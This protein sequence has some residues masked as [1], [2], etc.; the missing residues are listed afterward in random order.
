[1]QVEFHVDFLSVFL[2]ALNKF[3]W[4]NKMAMLKLASRHV[5]PLQS[6]L[7]FYQREAFRL[8]L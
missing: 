8:L 6:C 7:I 1:M 2:A 3:I 5:D 4:L